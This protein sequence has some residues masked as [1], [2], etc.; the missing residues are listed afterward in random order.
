MVYGRYQCWIYP[1]LG[2][3]GAAQI[4]AMKQ[5]SGRLR[6]DLAQY[7]ELAAF[8]Q[9]GS[10]LDK[11]TQDTLNRG[12]RMVE[13]LKQKQY[14]PMPV[15]E[16]VITLFAAGNGYTDDVDV[17]DILRFEDELLEYMRTRHK[18]ILTE[19]TEKKVLSEE[20]QEQLA[21]AV[22]DFK[23]SFQA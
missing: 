13:S 18:E 23:E 9:F 6:M 4:K 10:D 12:V 11:V 17:H 5:V 21:V 1:F 2:V 15:A 3:D 7:R 16:Q 8:S 20:L 22:H 19:I 14:A